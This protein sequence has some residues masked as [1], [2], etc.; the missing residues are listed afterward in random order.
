MVNRSIQTRNIP[1]LFLARKHA[2]Y[3][4]VIAALFMLASR[5]IHARNFVVTNAGD[6]GPETFRTAIDSANSIPGFDTISFNI[7]IFDTMVI[8][9]QS[10]LPP[11]IDSAGV[12]IDGYSQPFSGNWDST[13]L[14]LEP[15]IVLDGSNA[16]P[17][18]GICIRSSYNIVQGIII[19]NFEQDGIRIEATPTGTDM[20]HIYANLIGTECCDYWPQGNGTNQIEPWAGVNIVCPSGDSGFARHNLIELSAICANYSE[21]VRITGREAYDVIFNVVRN[22]YIGIS[23]LGYDFGN[24]HNG[25]YISEGAHDIIVE[26]NNICYNGFDGVGIVGNAINQIYTYY[27]TINYNYISY[28]SKN[29]IAIGIYGDSLYQ[30]FAKVNVISLNKIYSNGGSGI[31]L[32]ENPVN[33]SNADANKITRNSCDGNQLLGIDLGADGV[34]YNDSS[35]LDVGPNQEVNFPVIDYVSETAPGHETWVS[36]YVNIDTDPRQA[37]VEI[38]GNIGQDPSGYGEGGQCVGLATPY[39]LAGQWLALVGGLL[40]GEYVSAT[41]TDVN[42]NT[43]EFSMCHY[44]PGGGDIAETIKP[45]V[46]QGYDLSQNLPNPFAN[47]TRIDFSIPIGSYVDIKIYNITGSLVKTLISEDCTASRHSIVWD[48]TNNE[49]EILASGVYLYRMKT[50][51]FETTKRMILIK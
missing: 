9:L 23:Q 31:T 43:S 45:P 5:G 46:Y 7:N 47:S 15:F 36:G 50:D 41:V 19:I 40:P 8:W 16:G 20:N 34:T 21:G 2:V 12:F 27:N 10:E 4:I 3:F 37:L 39:N 1:R 28:N 22:N 14:H 35:D 32:W 49:G 17:S 24:A 26:G 11:L 18:H 30:G 33:E 29:G 44:V 51:E 25:V 48:G 38:F 6:S 13:V 42:M